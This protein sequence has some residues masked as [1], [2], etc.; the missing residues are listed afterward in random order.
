[1]QQNKDPSQLNA[2]LEGSRQ[3]LPARQHSTTGLSPQPSLT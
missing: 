2:L 1:M 3:P